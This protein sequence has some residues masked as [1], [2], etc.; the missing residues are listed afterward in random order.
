MPAKLADKIAAD[1]LVLGSGG[2]VFHAGPLRGGP[3]SPAAIA[4]PLGH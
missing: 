3:L 4:I 1:A 2:T